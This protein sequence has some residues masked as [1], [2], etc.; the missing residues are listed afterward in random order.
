M[1]STILMLGLLGFVG[2]STVGK[3]KDF[4]SK[5][6]ATKR[7]DVKNPAQDVQ[8][9]LTQAENQLKAAV[10]EAQKSG[11]SA[12]Q[13]LSN[14]LFFKAQDSSLRGDVEVAELLFRF[15]IEL[16]PDDVYV[17]QRHALEL[18]RTGELDKALAELIEIQKVSPETEIAL[19]IAGIYTSLEKKD[20]ARQVYLDVLKTHP[21][22]EEAC[23]FLAKSHATEQNYKKANKL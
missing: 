15:L 19:I 18:I 8:I 12:V 9:D 13:F 22:N 4:E 2:C 14:D 16:N 6:H 1:R 21:K 17:K 11:E 20:E 3:H 23:I 10:K 7:A 5:K